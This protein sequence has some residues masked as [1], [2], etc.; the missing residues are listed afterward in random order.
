LGG[1]IDGVVST[2]GDFEIILCRF[3]RDLDVVKITQTKAQDGPDALGGLGA[4]GGSLVKVV[5]LVNLGVL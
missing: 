5:D 4:E 2:E 3:E 1:R